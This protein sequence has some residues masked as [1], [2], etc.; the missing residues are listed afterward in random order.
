MPTKPYVA[1][2]RVWPTKTPSSVELAT[3]KDKVANFVSFHGGRIAGEYADREAK[4]RGQRPELAKAIEHAIRLKATLV[5][6]HMGKL[7]RN[8]PVTRMLLE[9]CQSRGLDFA[10]LDN[11]D[12]HHKPSHVVAKMAYM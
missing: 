8:V 9:A 4:Q 12:I 7:V 1:Y 6:A 10:C 3:Q 2:F 5:I 11:Q